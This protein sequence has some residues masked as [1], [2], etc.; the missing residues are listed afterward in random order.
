MRATRLRR[1][2]DIELAR[3]K[4]ETRSDPLFTLR[5]RPNGTDRV[6]VAV[7]SPRAIGT[8]VRRNRA[9]RRLRDAV[10]TLLAPRA[11]SRGIDLFFVARPPAVDA[12]AASLR[13][14]A[15]RHLDALFSEPRSGDE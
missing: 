13:A 6:R 12:P 3:M 15:A 7:A 11:A 5:A 1:T 8:A 10:R 14:A 9:R 2:K 4:G